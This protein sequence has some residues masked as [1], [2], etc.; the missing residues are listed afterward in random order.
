MISGTRHSAPLLG[1][2]CAAFL[3]GSSVRAQET[4]GGARTP[5]PEITEEQR[6]TADELVLLTFYGDPA[7]DALTQGLGLF[8]KQYP[9][10]IRE[11]LV[12]Q[13]L[14]TGQVARLLERSAN[15]SRARA[16]RTL[17]ERL[18]GQQQYRIALRNMLQELYAENY[19]LDQ[20]RQLIAFWS[21]PAGRKFYR[22]SPVIRADRLRRSAELLRQPLL[23]LSAQVIAEETRTLTRGE[24]GSD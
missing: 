11:S 6:Q 1:M 18:S 12:A 15:E 3:L 9:T 21:S 4:Q 8:A 17:A 19:S 7:E 23:E 20:M 13:G 10:W 24:T 5:E 2:L 14:S 16:V 22:L